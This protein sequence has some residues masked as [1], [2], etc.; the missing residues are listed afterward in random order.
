[1]ASFKE[2]MASKRASSNAGEHVAPEL[3]KPGLMLSGKVPVPT[4]AMPDEGAL[5]RQLGIVPPEGVSRKLGETVA[6]VPYTFHSENDSHERKL[7]KAALLAEETKLG[8]WINPE[9]T[10]AE[11]WIAVQVQGDPNLLLLHRL[12]LFNRKTELSAPF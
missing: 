1:M 5:L 8:V 2:L 6:D 10:A 3:P 7:L 9:S 11:A 12:P 4:V